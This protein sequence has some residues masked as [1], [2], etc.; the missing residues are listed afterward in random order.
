MTHDPKDVQNFL[1]TFCSSY[2]SKCDFSWR[3][4]A[5]ILAILSCRP[6]VLTLTILNWRENLW[7]KNSSVEMFSLGLIARYS[8]F[9]LPTDS[10][11]YKKQNWHCSIH[12]M[13][14]AIRDPCCFPKFSAGFLNAAATFRKMKEEAAGAISK[15]HLPLQWDIL[16]QLWEASHGD[17]KGPCTSQG[18][19]F[20][21][22]H[23]H[24]VLASISTT[25]R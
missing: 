9:L 16:K 15:G 5:A 23:C 8:Q 11:I 18:C 21:G 10:L 19:H 3:V 20:K 22:L 25:S 24:W 13:F 2:R 17:F 6:L 12:G 14:F 4:L 7:L 1:E